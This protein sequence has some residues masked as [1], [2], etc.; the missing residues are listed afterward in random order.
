MNIIALKLIT[1][2][3]IIAEL[4]IKS[5]NGT[6]YLKNP[7]QIASAPSHTGQIQ[8]MFIPFPKFI[9]QQELNR[10]VSISSSHVILVYDPDQELI[11][12]YNSMFGSGIV[13]AS[14]KFI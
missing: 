12:Q 13:V 7:V 4:V 5:E 2:E 9:S 8:V 6:Y 14:N 10:E 11:N 3:D 1:G